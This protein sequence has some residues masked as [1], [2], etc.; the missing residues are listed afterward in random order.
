MTHKDGLRLVLVL[1]GLFSFNLI[2]TLNTIILELV[3]L[4]VFSLSHTVMA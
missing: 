4:E 3:V 1:K 2:S